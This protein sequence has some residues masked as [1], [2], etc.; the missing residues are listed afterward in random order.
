MR[1]LSGPVTLV[2]DVT[3]IAVFGTESTGKTSLA[4]LLAT[5]FR[6]PWSREF[7]REF[8]DRHDGKIE[9]TD[10]AAIAR[11]QIAN[12]EEAA[13]TARRVLFCD[14]ELITCTLWNDTLFPGECPAWVRQQAEVRAKGFAL[15]LLCDADVPFVHDPQRCFPDDE[16]RERARLLWRD[17]LVSRGLPFVEIRGDWRNRER[18]AITAVE[19]VLKKKAGEH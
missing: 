12:E 8:W 19:D 10:L 13:A 9:P 15:Y 6:E 18:T 14:T 7:A 3:R 17:A 5:H 16:S 1:G 2:A 4:E 11:G